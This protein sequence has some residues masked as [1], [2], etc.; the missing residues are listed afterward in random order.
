MPCC[1]H[2]NIYHQALEGVLWCNPFTQKQ[3]FLPPFPSSNQQGD[4]FP[5]NIKFP[6]F[7]LTFPVEASKD[8][9]VS[10][11]SDMVNSRSFISV[12]NRVRPD[13]QLFNIWGCNS[14]P[15]GSGWSL[16]AKRYLMNFKLK[17]SISLPLTFP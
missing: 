10:S 1:V 11:V 12:K 14:S 6:D 13:S 8:Y 17:I 4:H 16:A 3:K 7:S 5:D 15:S 2:L 9:P